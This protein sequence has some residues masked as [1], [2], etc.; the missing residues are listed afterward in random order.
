[1]TSNPQ[2][3]RVLP[4]KVDDDN[5]IWLGGRQLFSSDSVTLGDLPAISAVELAGAA[6][7]YRHSRS[8]HEIITPQL[9]AVVYDI[10]T[11]DEALSHYFPLLKSLTAESRQDF[12]KLRREV[13]AHPHLK[14]EFWDVQGQ[15]TAI[16]P[17]SMRQIVAGY[18]A[19]TFFYRPDILNRFLETDRFINIYLNS[20]AYQKAGGVSG[21]CYDPRSESIKLVAQRLYEG[22]YQLSPGVAP[23]LH[24]FGHMLDAFDA[25][26]GR[27]RHGDGYLP[28]LHHEDGTL[29]TASARE[30]FDAGKRLEIDRYERCY[31]AKTPDEIPIGHPYVF[32]NDGEFI[33][34]YLEM[35]FRNPHYFAELNPTLYEG[36]TTLFRQ[37][38]RLVWDTDFDFYVKSNRSV[39]LDPGRNIPRHG[40]TRR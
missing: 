6:E 5:R 36:F 22:F 18:I 30:L 16:A 1:M 17:S 7:R 29:F 35:F 13:A 20:K 8:W 27:M 11:D 15:V 21:G 33:A 24:E 38:T 19:E 31:S 28:G 14:L 4:F 34:G 23:F 10:T 2:D 37:D 39:Y 3:I 26:T 32:Q 9:A 40:L 12:F 25:A